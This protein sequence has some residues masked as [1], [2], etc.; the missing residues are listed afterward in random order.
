M[1]PF[2]G[3]TEYINLL[4]FQLHTNQ[5]LLIVDLVRSWLTSAG[6]RSDTDFRNSSVQLTF[7]DV[8]KNVHCSFIIQWFLCC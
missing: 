7:V 6:H 5:Q 8:M 2:K 3:L 4:C 1:S